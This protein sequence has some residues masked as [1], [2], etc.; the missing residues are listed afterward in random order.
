MEHGAKCNTSLF[1]DKSSV[2]SK[3]DYE[4]NAPHFPHVSSINRMKNKL[5]LP[6]TQSFSLW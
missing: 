6:P 3:F 2:C 4:E 5:P 1:H